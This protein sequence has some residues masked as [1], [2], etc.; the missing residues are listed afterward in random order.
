MPLHQYTLDWRHQ[1]AKTGNYMKIRTKTAEV[2]HNL[3]KERNHL[4]QQEL[5]VWYDCGC[6]NKSYFSYNYKILQNIYKNVV[7]FCTP[8]NKNTKHFFS[9]TRWLL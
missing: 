8:T 3:K 7:Q 6:K 2:H 5:S 9:W 4:F 1:V